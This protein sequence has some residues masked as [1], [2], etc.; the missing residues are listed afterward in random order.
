MPPAAGAQWNWSLYW[1]GF[2]LG[3]G[4]MSAVVAGIFG[5]GG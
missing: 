3:V 5:L 4:L 1:I 2:A